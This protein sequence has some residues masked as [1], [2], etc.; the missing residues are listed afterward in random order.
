MLKV[1]IGHSEDI[2]A[3]DAINEVIEQCNEE[4]DGSFPNAAILFAAIDFDHKEILNRVNKEF[5]G[6]QLIGGT[7]DGEMS[8]KEG[9][10][11]DSVTMICFHSDDLEFVVGCGKNVSSNPISVSKNATDAAK[12]NLSSE[13]K[14]CL[15]CFES[16]TTSALMIIK[17]L[18]ESL[19]VRFPILGGSSGDQFRF[20]QTFQ[21]Y[22]NEVLTDSATIMLISGDLKYSYGVATGWQPIGNKYKVTKSENNIVY[23]IEG[24]PAIDF[25]NNM[26]GEYQT[27]SPE[28]P[29]AVFEESDMHFFL[30]AP[31]ANNDDG[32]IS[33]AADVEEGAVFQLTKTDRDSIVAASEFSSRKAIDNYPGNKPIVA[34]ITSCAARRAILGTRVSEEYDIIRKSI[35]DDIKIFGFYSY[36]EVCPLS[37][38]GKAHFHNETIVTLIMGE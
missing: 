16:L 6:I 24:I 30:R 36:G 13:P 21:F 28:Y 26:L 19:G 38:N 35:S 9:F 17:G 32:S 11:E 1:S 37:V 8:S 3:I 2:D 4:L 22:N 23:E 33:F 15:T 10:L 7:T 18:Q 29:L 12:Q 34:F 14:I 25:Y 20:K 27:I 31:M 5:P